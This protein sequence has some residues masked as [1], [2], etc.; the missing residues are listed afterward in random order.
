MSVHSYNTGDISYGL[1]V[2]MVWGDFDWVT[3][4]H[5]VNWFVA[6]D[7]IIRFIEPQT[8]TIYEASHC[9]GQVSLFVV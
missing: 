4:Y 9:Q 5:A 1:C 8:D 7:N 6:S 2:G 3:G